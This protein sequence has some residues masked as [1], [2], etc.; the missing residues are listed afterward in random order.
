MS[1]FVLII[2][3]FA[4]VFIA[5]IVLFLI[6]IILPLRYVL[7]ANCKDS[8]L[9][10]DFR[11]TFFYF[12]FFVDFK[13]MKNVK[14]KA[15]I[16]GK[17]IADSENKK[18]EKFAKDEDE[19][20][21][22][23][24]FFKNKNLDKE[25]N[26]SDEVFLNLFKRSK[27]YE[28]EIETTEKKEERERVELKERISRFVDNYK[29]VLPLSM[30]DLAKLISREVV[31]YA[32]YILPKKLKA[33]VNVGLNEPSNTGLLLAF[34]AP[35]YAGFGDSIDISPD[36]TKMKL[37]GGLTL[38]GRPQIIFMIIPIIHLFLNKRFR[39]IVLSKR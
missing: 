15:K 10:C 12:D 26:T 8:K 35:L 30:I 38:E 37:D 9:T 36:F 27:E 39:E 24:K 33:N 3:I 34:L 13:D 16:F 22:L 17:V 2:K 6:F 25:I 20:I 32:P 7:V 31:D 29:K 23:K 5:I 14:Y 18:K 11:Y 28:K 4:F 1:I 19:K 21:D